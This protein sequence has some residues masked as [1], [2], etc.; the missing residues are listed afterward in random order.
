L[1]SCCGPTNEK[2]QQQQQQQ[3]QKTNI[4]DATV[5]LDSATS[6]VRWKHGIGWEARN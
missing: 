2:Q 6:S 1:N 3:Q 5:N 4:T